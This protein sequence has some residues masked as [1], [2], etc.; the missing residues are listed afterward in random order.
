MK[1]AIFLIC[2]FV[3]GSIVSA[4]NPFLSSKTAVDEDEISYRQH[5]ELG[6]V[7]WHRDFEKGKSIARDTGKPMFVLFQ[8]VPGCQT[9]RDYGSRP[10]SHPLIVEAIEDLFCAGGRF[11]QQGRGRCIYLATVQRKIVEQSCGSIH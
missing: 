5:V 8:E 10:M 9:C 1:A 11:Q 4:L 3:L 2:F 7:H 6:E